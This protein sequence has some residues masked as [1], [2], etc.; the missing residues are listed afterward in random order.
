MQSSWAALDLTGFSTS[1]MSSK[2]L[3]PWIMLIGS[4][5][6]TNAALG[7]C[8]KIDIDH[9]RRNDFLWEKHVNACMYSKFTRNHK[10]KQWDYDTWWDPWPQSCIFKHVSIVIFNESFSSPLESAITMHHFV[11]ASSRGTFTGISAKV[12]GDLRSDMLILCGL[13]C[14]AGFRIAKRC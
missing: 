14:V 13:V 9:A 7:A 1:A 6:A 10:S 3:M 12:S 8:R 2:M 5:G 4:R 11:E